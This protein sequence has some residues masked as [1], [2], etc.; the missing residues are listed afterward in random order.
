MTLMDHL[1]PLA[2]SKIKEA[3]LKTLAMVMVMDKEFVSRLM[4][5]DCQRE[6]DAIKALNKI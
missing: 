3:L 6:K 2:I 4:A 5:I 1:L